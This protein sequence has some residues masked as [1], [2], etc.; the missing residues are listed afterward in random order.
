MN[1]KISKLRNFKNIQGSY[2]FVNPEITTEFVSTVIFDVKF[3]ELKPVM[4]LSLNKSI[5]DF[6]DE[7]KKSLIEEVYRRKIYN[8]SKEDLNG[9]FVDPVKTVKQGKKLAECVKMKITDPDIKKL[10]KKTNVKCGVSISSVWFNE[11]SFGV[12]LNVTKVE[13]PEKKCL[14]VDS[15]CESEINL[16]I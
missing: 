15:D 10:S 14:I 6:L 4:M 11:T 13:I 9:Y 5:E 7:L 16:K 8:C 3:N 2:A 1:F 12:Y